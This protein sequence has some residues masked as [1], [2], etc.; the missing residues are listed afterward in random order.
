MYGKQGTRDV[1][2][3]VMVTSSL[4]VYPSNRFILRTL[5]EDSKI[6]GG[7][8]IIQELIQ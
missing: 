7:E 8:E 4:Q 1:S 2:G 6:G 3:P 5:L